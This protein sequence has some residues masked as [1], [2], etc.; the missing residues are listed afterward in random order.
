M[1]EIDKKTGIITSDK[2]YTIKFGS[3]FIHVSTSEGGAFDLGFELVSSGQ[4]VMVYD[5]TEVT[6]QNVSSEQVSHTVETLRALG[7]NVEVS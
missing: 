4:K 6:N 3:N 2:G 5:D 1:A 7:F